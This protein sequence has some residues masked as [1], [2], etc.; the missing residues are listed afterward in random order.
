MMADGIHCWW[1]EE[2][3]SLVEALV[4]M[5]VLS[6]ILMGVASMFA[7]SQA[8]IV[9]G[10]KSLETAALAQTRIERL[11]SMPYHDLLTS[12]LEGNGEADL[13]IEDSGI[14]EFSAR[15]NVRGVDLSWSVVPDGPLS[16]SRAVTIKVTAGWV[17]ARGQH[18]TIRFGMRRANPVY[19]GA[20]G[21]T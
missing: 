3:C 14:G 17:D 7:F 15:Q 19:S 9:G 10:A 16:K 5:A 20:G 18:R 6:V 12:S 8:G 11:R 1:S 4:A 21:G 13:V 2:G